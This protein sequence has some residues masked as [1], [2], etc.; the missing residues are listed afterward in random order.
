MQREKK[1]R[2]LQRAFDDRGYEKGD[3]LSFFCPKHPARA[4]RSIGQL[5]VNLKTDWFNCWSCGWAGKT[6]VPLLRLRGNTEELQEYLQELEERRGKKEVKPEKKYDPVVLPDEFKSL[7]APCR[8]PYQK[9][10]MAYLAQRGVSYDDILLWKLGFCEDGEY[11]NRIIIPSFDEYGELNFF[12]GRAIYE[13]PLKYKHGNFDKDIITNDYMIDWSRP[14]T[15][16]EGAFDAIQ[17]GENAIALQGSILSEGS[18][19]FRKIVTSG[20][21][22]YFALDSDAFKKQ[23]QI[24]ELFMSYGVNAFHVNLFGKKDVGLMTKHEFQEAKRL[25]RP[26]RS[27]TD[28]LRI[29][30]N[31]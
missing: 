18:R 5:H 15:V 24:I 7:S 8:S 13:N 26:I 9:A 10:A 16:T 12:T 21:D 1:L 2:A 22:T 3:E 6:L 11:K 17:A 28:I 30:I 23:L 20:V 31:A 14:V 27:E 4:G 29:R 19:L 25:A